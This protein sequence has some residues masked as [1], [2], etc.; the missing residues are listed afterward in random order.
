M[1]QR[2]AATKPHAFVPPSILL[3]LYL[4]LAECIMALA[5]PTAV[6]AE[7]APA[8]PGQS[9]EAIQPASSE[10]HSATSLWE[11]ANLYPDP[12]GVRASLAENGL[13]F[14]LSE[15]S[16]VFGNPTGGVR[17]G[18]IY[19]GLTQLG[20]GLDTGKA[21]LWQG[22]TFNVGAF[23]IHGRGLSL[24]NLGNNLNTVSSIEAYRGTLLFELWYEQALFDKQLQIR[25]GQL[26]ADQE[27]M[28]SQYANLFLNHTFGWSTL[29]SSD[30]PSGGAAYPLATPGVRVRWFP[31]D[32]LTLLAAVLDGNPAGPGPAGSIPQFRDA[33]GT[34]FRLNDGIVVIAEAQYAINQG[35]A[36]TG[37]AGTYKVGGWYNS[38]TFADQGHNAADMPLSSTQVP[39]RNRRGDWSLYAVADQ[40]VWRKAGQKD[41]GIGVFGRI[42]GAPGDRNL[43]NFYVDAG[44]TWK[45]AIEVRDSDT[46]GLGVGYARISDTAAKLDSSI[47]AATGGFYP[48]RRSETV[49][50]LT[51]QAQIAPWLQVQ[52]TAQYIFNPNGGVPDPNNATRRL[53]DAV[54]L[55][56]RTQ[57]TF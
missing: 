17:Q 32:D 55:G 14:G 9:G 2:L 54:V 8:A 33:S 34:A 45:G 56:L 21:G 13:T 16:E 46:A 3:A 42:M 24:N 38:G 6:R 4:L 11:R 7:G 31:R 49:L 12:G 23:Q 48:I 27:F 28:I 26:A 47:A 40:L 25:V 50:E 39:G 30:L 43:V 44:V 20:L 15:V 19:E 35:D 18:A 10:N 53:P 1:V 22:G 29:P 37:L 57:I 52:P 36:A 5:L 41:G 51:Y